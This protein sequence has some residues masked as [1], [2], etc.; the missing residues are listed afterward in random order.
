MGNTF[1]KL[2]NKLFNKKQTMKTLMLGL[3]GAGKTT[4][5]KKIQLGKVV[6]SV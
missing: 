3:D 4:M 1:T 2:F 6:N 5:L